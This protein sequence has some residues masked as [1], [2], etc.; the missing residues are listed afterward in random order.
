MGASEGDP[1]STGGS[2]RPGYVYLGVSVDGY[3][4]GPGGELDWLED[5]SH[6]SGEPLHLPYDVFV[7]DKDVL[8]MGRATCEKV[9][10]FGFWPFEGRPAVV[11]TSRPLDVPSELEGRVE[12]DAGTP[13]EVVARLQDRGLRRLYVDGGETVRRF[14]R[15]G[16]VEELVL[17]QVPVLLG[18]GVS[19]FGGLGVP[20]KL[21]LKWAAP[22]RNGFVQSCYRVNG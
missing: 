21:E 4:A 18:G 13:E 5:P 9:L 19:L 12:V 3:I 7:A 1:G 22:A 14:L 16:L 6:A 2:G 17:T 11:L 8:V 15:A 10:T 20:V